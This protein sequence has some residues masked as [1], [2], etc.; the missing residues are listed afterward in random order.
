VQVV[1]TDRD[2]TALFGW[3]GEGR[4]HVRL[5]PPRG[6]APLPPPSAP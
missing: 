6:P 1:R 3:N 5:H 4:L 2:G